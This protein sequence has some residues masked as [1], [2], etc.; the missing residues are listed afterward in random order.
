M[1]LLL[2]I[3]I[4]CVHMMPVSIKIVNTVV[5]IPTIINKPG[6]ESSFIVLVV[7]ILAMFIE[8]FSL[9]IDVLQKI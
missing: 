3:A 6:L 5:A 8:I 7:I 1:T 4:L 2:F 9:K